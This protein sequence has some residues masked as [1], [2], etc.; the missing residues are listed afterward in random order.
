MKKLRGFSVWIFL[1]LGSCDFS[2]P[3]D[4]SAAD[5]E[6]REY[7]ARAKKREANILSYMKSDVEITVWTSL[8]E[9]ST[10]RDSLTIHDYTVL[11]PSD[12]VLR[13]EGLQT[14]QDLVPAVRRPELNALIGK[15]LILGRVS[16][17]E[18]AD[19]TVVNA[20]GEKLHVVSKTIGG[21]ELTSQAHEC[22]RGKLI[23]VRGVLK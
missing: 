13:N 23:R 18:N 1:A 22:E 3:V 19:T 16:F 2:D 10:W 7:Q 8:V 21:I 9:L 20:L 17:K 4:L 15:H 5:K 11:T 14:F 6:W 12:A